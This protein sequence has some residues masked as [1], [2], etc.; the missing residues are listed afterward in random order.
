VTGSRTRSTSI[1]RFVEDNWL[2]GRRIAGGV[3]I[4]FTGIS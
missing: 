2:G 3:D 4:H 1:L